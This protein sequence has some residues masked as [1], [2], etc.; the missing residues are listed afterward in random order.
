VTNNTKSG[1]TGTLYG[2]AAFTANRTLNDNDTLTVTVTLTA[3][4]A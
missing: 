1:T 2:G 3:A 4:N